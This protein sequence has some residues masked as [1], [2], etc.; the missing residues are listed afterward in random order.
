MRS[1]GQPVIARLFARNDPMLNSGTAQTNLPPVRLCF[2]DPGQT[3][4]WKL[5]TAI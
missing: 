1:A 3:S 2:V 4:S 5:R